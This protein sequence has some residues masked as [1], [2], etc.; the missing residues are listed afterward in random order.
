MTRA[1]H[2]DKEKLA[3]TGGL[4]KEPKALQAAPHRLAQAFPVTFPSGPLRACCCCFYKI[5]K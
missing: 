2:G 1:V 3:R 4:K 5:N